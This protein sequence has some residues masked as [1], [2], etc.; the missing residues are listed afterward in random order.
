MLQI[1]QHASFQHSFPERVKAFC[2]KPRTKMRWW[3]WRCWQNGPSYS[4]HFYLE[5]KVRSSSRCL[6]KQNRRRCN[7][8]VLTSVTWTGTCDDVDIIQKC[9]YYL[10]KRMLTALGNMPA[11]NQHAWT[12]KWCMRGWTCCANKLRWACYHLSL[13][14]LSSTVTAGFI[15]G[16][17]LRC[18]PC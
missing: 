17:L 13:T 7:H 4:F 11:I 12:A 14:A 15:F 6:V 18:C 5:D 16:F 2:L 10:S 3:P 8:S 1:L 9:I